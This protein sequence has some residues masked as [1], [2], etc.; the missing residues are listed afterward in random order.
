MHTTHTSR[1]QSRGGSH[2]SHEENTKSL[3]LE[4]DR[5]CRRL[6]RERRRRTPS[7]SNPSS[8]DNE[9]GSYR[10]RFR[11]PPSKFFLYYKNRYYEQRSATQRSGN[12]AMSK[13]LN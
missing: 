13:A 9:D 5:F 2:I 8:K 1:S 6:R 7:N 10:P 12:D 4:I 11:T 3:Q